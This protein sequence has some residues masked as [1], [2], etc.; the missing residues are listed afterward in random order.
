MN[1]RPVAN[2][3]L[4]EVTT[5]KYTKSGPYIPETSQKP[6]GK[7]VALGDGQNQDGTTTHFFA[8][9]GDTI[10]LRE[11]YGH[12]E[13]D[14]DGKKYRLVSNTDIIAVVTE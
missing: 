1:L 4:I 14:M 9:A 13:V 3:V 12:Q 8:N 5:T 2:L 11:G 6:M 7:V 10:L